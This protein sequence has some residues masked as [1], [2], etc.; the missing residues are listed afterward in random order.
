MARAAARPGSKWM[1]ARA[2]IFGDGKPIF[3]SIP[4]PAIQEM[5]VL[6]KLF[7]RRL[8]RPITQFDPV[9]FGPQYQ[10]PIS[11]GGI[12]TSGTSQSALLLNRPYEVSDTVSSIRGRHALKAGARVIASIRAATAKNSAAPSTRVSS[13]TTPVLK[14]WPFAKATFIWVTSPMCGRI[15]RAMA[16]RSTWSTMFYGRYSPRTTFAF[17]RIS[18]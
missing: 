1:A 10:V 12:L 2:A 4:L 18:R 5:T 7:L 14:A 15:R 11:T 17:V 3:T 9:V 8:R 13:S 6:V 16:P